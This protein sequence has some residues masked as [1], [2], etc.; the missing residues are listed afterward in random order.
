MT[1]LLSGSPILQNAR[2]IGAV[3]HVMINDPCTGYGIF[4]ENMLN[5]AESLRQGYYRYFSIKKVESNAFIK[6]KAQPFYSTCTRR[7][8]YYVRD[9]AYMRLIALPARFGVGH[10]LPRKLAEKRSRFMIKDGEV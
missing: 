1:T 10:I 5:A 6:R 2:L 8:L 4:I 9:G 3:T 7:I